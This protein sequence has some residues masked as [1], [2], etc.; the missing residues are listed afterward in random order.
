MTNTNISYLRLLNII[1]TFASSYLG[2]ERFGSDFYEQ[3]SDFSSKGESFPLLYVAPDINTYSENTNNFNLRVYCVDRMEKDRSNVSE[4]L[5][6]TDKVLND[7]VIWINDNNFGVDINLPVT[8]T[9]INNPLMDNVIGRYM[10]IDVFVASYGECE[11]PFIT[12]PVISGFTC[13]IQYTNEYL[14]CSDLPECSIIEEM[15]TSISANT[16]SIIDLGQEVEDGFVEISELIQDLAEDVSTLQTEVSANTASILTL[17]NDSNEYFID[18]RSSSSESFTIGTGTTDDI[19]FRSPQVSIS[20]TANG[21]EITSTGNNTG[22]VKFDKWKWL[23][24]SNRSIEIIVQKHLSTQYAQL[25]I[26]GVLTN[27]TSLSQWNGFAELAVQYRQNDIANLISNNG[28]PGSI[29]TQ[30]V[31]TSIASN[32]FLKFRIETDGG[33]RSRVRVFAIDNATDWYNNSTPILD[34]LGSFNMNPDE[35][36]LCIW[37]TPVGTVTQTI[38]AARIYEGADLMKVPAG[39]SALSGLTDVTITGVTTGQA[40]I[41][42]GSSW[43]NQNIPT[44]VSALSGLTDVSISGATA[45]EALLYNGTDWYNGPVATSSEGSMGIA[46]DGFGGTIVAGIQYQHLIVPFACTID[47]WSIVADT[48]GTLGID[49]WRAN[50]AIPTSGDTIVNSNFITLSSQQ[51]NSDSNLSGWTSTSLVAGD[52]LNF[53]VYTASTVTKATLTLKITK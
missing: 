47:N 53:N 15:N 22:W 44:P 24:G 4:V 41:Y 16:Q 38:V 2:V 52:I 36:E 32:D 17:T 3:L 8:S 26:G 33:R 27:E 34:T 49:I 51:I 35:D 48:T 30:S 42:S 5:S 31:S 43:T 29:Q 23:R 39:Q 18:F 1:E 14:T 25:G 10:D 9:P 19:R 20:R 13:D 28:T 7:L 40:L 46:F 11:I 50:N 21:L 37:M 6:M 12:S 45:G